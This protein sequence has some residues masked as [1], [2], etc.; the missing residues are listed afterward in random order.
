MLK[1]IL[2]I[3]FLLTFNIEAKEYNSVHG[4]TIQ[5]PDSYFVISDFKQGLVP[6]LWPIAVICVLILP[7]DFSTAALLFIVCFVMLFV[8]GAKLKHL[9]SIVGSAIVGF[10]FLVLL[11]DLILI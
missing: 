1:I 3:I 9:G 10:L 4:F 6:I 5:I 11:Y 8:G 2:P 7:A